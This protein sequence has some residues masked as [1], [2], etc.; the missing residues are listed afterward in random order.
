MKL[1]D[2]VKLADKSDDINRLK[3]DGYFLNSGM[4]FLDGAANKVEKWTLT[5]YNAGLN[6]VAQIIVD[7]GSAIVKEIGTPMH[8]TKEQLKPGDIKTSSEKMLE[9][10]TAEFKKHN[11]PASQIIMSIQNE[12]SQIIWSI[13]FITKLLFLISIKIDA[14]TGEVISSQKTSLAK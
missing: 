13:S 1:A 11:Q 12:G 6:K 2:A 10:A 8:P 9:K 14:K 3:K 7:E 5:Y 4:A